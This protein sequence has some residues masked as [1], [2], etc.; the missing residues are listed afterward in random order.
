MKRLFW[1]WAHKCLDVPP[2]AEAFE[3]PKRTFHASRQA[4]TYKS[5]R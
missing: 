4:K 2:H 1:F 3:T 5:K